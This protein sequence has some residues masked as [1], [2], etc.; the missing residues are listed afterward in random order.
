MMWLVENHHQIS[1]GHYV[2]RPSRSRRTRNPYSIVVQY[3]LNRLVRCTMLNSIHLTSP[4]N[5]KRIGRQSQRADASMRRPC[6]K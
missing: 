1:K 3:S 2:L 4:P 6:V 5:G